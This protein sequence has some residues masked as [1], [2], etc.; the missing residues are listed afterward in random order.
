MLL[1]IFAA[2]PAPASPQWTMRP[3]IGLRIG[4]A[5]AKASALP[6]AMKVSVPAAA[7]PV[8]PETGASI[9]SRPCLP[10]I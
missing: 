1:Q 2:W 8:P 7:P 6:P 9:D 4:S 5:L 10:A 3:A